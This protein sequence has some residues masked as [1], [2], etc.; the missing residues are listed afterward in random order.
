MSCELKFDKINAFTAKVNV[1]CE[2]T[3]HV[4]RALIIL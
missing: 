4:V 3:K 2:G 1:L